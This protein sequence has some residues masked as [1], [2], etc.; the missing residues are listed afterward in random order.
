MSWQDFVVRVYFITDNLEE[1]FDRPKN[2]RVNIKI[3]DPSADTV[4]SIIDNGYYSFAKRIYWN[5]LD[6]AGDTC[7]T[8]GMYNIIVECEDKVGNY[9]FSTLEFEIDVSP[10]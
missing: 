10:P 1:Y 8:E 4:W 6:S 2:G 3:R 5:F 9:G 7:L